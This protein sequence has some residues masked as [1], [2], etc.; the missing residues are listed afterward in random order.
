MIPRR[1]RTRSQAP[2]LGFDRRGVYDA[3]RADEAQLEALI[4]CFI[5]VANKKQPP[6]VRDRLARCV[7]DTLST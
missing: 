1:H 7:S 6:A 2:V 3:E 4:D 5:A